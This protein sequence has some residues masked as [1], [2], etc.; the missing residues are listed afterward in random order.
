M[1]NYIGK[2]IDRYRIIER[3]G[4]GGMAVVYKAY[5]VR[6]EREV[7]LKLIRTEEIPASQHERLIK[8]FE[9]EAKAQARFNHRH[10]VPVH[11]YGV[12]DGS[13][14]LV[15]A[16]V[17]GGTL[18]DKIG[19]PVD[20]QQA[21]AWLLPIADAL[22]YAHQRGIVHRD[23]KP[24]NILFDEAGQ[25]L[26]TDFGIAKILETD[27]AT[28]TGTGLGVGTPEYMAPE[29]WQGQAEAATDQYALGVV[30]YE[31]LTGQKPYSAETPVAIAL[32]QMNDPL[33]RPSA[34]VNGIPESVEKVLF[35]ALAKDPADRYADM[36]A[37]QKALSALDM[38]VGQAPAPERMESRKAA[39]ATT[40]PAAPPRVDSEGVTVDVLEAP[41][42]SS[43][44]SGKKK[45][46]G[47]LWGVG[48]AVV[49]LLILLVVFWPQGGEKESPVAQAT[50]I[51][52]SESNE[53]SEEV[54]FSVVLLVP[55]ALGDQSFIDSS[56][57][58]IERANEE[59]SV[60]ADIIVTQSSAEQE[61]ALHS[62]IAQ[63]YDIIL[64]LA[65]DPF[66]L[67]TICEEFPDQKFA[68]PSEVFAEE[69]PANLV[70]Y[71]INVHES[72]FLAGLVAGSLTKT[73]IVG[74]V[75][76]GDAPGLNQYFY[77]YKQGVLEVCP[78]CEVMLSY[79][80]FDFRNPT[81]GKETTAA[82]YDEGADIV[83]AIAGRSGEGVLAASAEY[84]LYSIGVDSN[85][86]DIAPGH[87]LVS[88]IKRMDITTFKSIEMVVNGTYEG[89]FYELGMAD[90]A[91]GLSW[92]EGSTTFRD[93]G[94]ED[95]V[96]QL[97]DIEALVEE[98]R[99]KI[100][101]GEYA[102]CNALLD[103][104]MTSNICTP[105]K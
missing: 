35:K 60:Q 42:A 55:N 48:A 85:Q 31:L 22:A 21:V 6:L 91:A 86:D 69:L 76:G 88:M 39:Q 74:A 51:I 27:E 103:A 30:L 37:F 57:R 18:K 56:A 19:G 81:L 97:D 94:P 64:P 65:F 32:K 38:T 75:V 70:S 2:Q 44:T 26:L 72:S 67:I 9:R 20:Y 10:I 4:M 46:P 84:D 58:G 17:E 8:R 36:G 52:I 25:P 92:D 80:G 47:W 34:V 79:L 73:K 99:T 62:A 54:T 29:Q 102:V 95:M 41:S 1:Q 100:L 82:Q 90:G 53:P 66:L 89:G 7:A 101:D 63:G 105:L 59:L 15:M 28:L 24:T 96:A 5:D 43:S 71:Q 61:S 45:V 83:F 87:V 78:D 93:N 104:K 3:L 11:D 13:P 49:V 68:S 12:V 14:Y 23:V 40:A 50:D 33:P 16:Y 77:G 98:Y